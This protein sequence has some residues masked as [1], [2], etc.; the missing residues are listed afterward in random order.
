MPKRLVSWTVAVGL[1]VI[2]TPATPAAASGP[3]ASLS[4]SSLSFGAVAWLKSASQDVLLTNSGDSALTGIVVQFSQIY[5]PIDFAFMSGTCPATAFTLAPGAQCTIG[6]RFQPQSGGPRTAVMSV[7]DNAA[8]SP[9]SV[10]LTGTGT[11]AVITFSPV[12][13]QFPSVPVG[14]TSPP[15]SFSAINAGDAAVTITSATLGPGHSSWFA[16]NADGCTGHTLGPG[17]RCSMSATAS[18]DAVT[19]ESEDVTFVDGAGTGQQI[20]DLARSREGLLAGGDG[21]LLDTFGPIAASI[22]DVGTESSPTKVLVH[23]SGTLPLQ[24]SS[25]AVDDPSSGFRISADTCSG[26][27]VSVDTLFSP[28]SRCEV[29]IVFAPTAPGT[30]HANL[31]FHDNEFGGVRD[32]ALTGVGRAPAAE[33]SATAIDFGF[34]P[35]G[36]ASAPQVVSLSNPTTLPLT[37]TGVTLSGANP[38]SFG[39]TNDSCSGRTVPAGGNCAVAVTITPPFAFLF[40]ATLSFNDNAPFPQP[41]V[42]LRGEGRSPTFNITTSR[43]DF[44]ALRV[45]AASPPLTFGITN[46]TAGPLSIGF[47]PA[48][49]S[50]CP[51]SLAPGAS[52]TAAVSITP[53]ALGAQTTLLKVF[54]SSFNQQVVEIDYAGVTAEPHL[55]STF[56]NTVFQGVGET[57]TGY[58]FLRNAGQDDLHVGEVTLSGSSVAQITDDRCSNQSVPAGARCIITITIHPAAAGSWAATLAA[59]TDAALGP[60]E[61]MLSLQGIA[62][63]P[64]TPVFTP[65]SVTFPAQR[66][67]APEATRVVWFSNGVVANLGALPMTVGSVTLG[68]A[69]AAAFRIV[70]DGCTAVIVDPNF[71]CPVAVGFDPDQ[72]GPLTATLLFAD[73]GAGSPQAISL[74]G[75]G[76]APAVTFSPPT[77]A[78]GNVVVRTKSAPAIVTVGNSGNFALMISRVSV[79]GTDKGD[80]TITSEDCHNTT[81]APGTNC[82]V[83]IVFRPSA[84]GAE[85]A[86]LTVAD[87]APGSPQSALLTG[88]GISKK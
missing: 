48:L 10:A 79:S 15:Q 14:T 22:Q 28:P 4:T 43:L 39:L 3:E 42:L 70:W 59:P 5:V 27:T 11:G 84:T 24:I 64:P 72:S 86:T 9:Q 38:S 62:S 68:G 6:V 88:T 44:G 32:V 12:S 17:Q 41:S 40:T 47:L 34:Q 1:A 7:Y 45:N 13:L 31:V 23:D 75:I 25:V 35:V 54:D 66:V 52:C 61:S 80:F 30:F 53:T 55:E 87:D 18:P 2:I 50:G 20:Y 78:F 33:P 73:D 71:S 46:T 51:S 67:G 82:Q 81:L 8:D 74:S 19:S 65:S 56:G 58:A 37:V 49:A 21:S 63:P 57:V 36:A 60:N 69:N 29:D 16:I 83:T 85:S 26:A 76:L 77:F